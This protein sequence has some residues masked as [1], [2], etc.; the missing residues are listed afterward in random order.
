MNDKGNRYALSALK[1]RR[2][3]V[4]SEIVSLERQMKHC[5]DSL[6]HVDATLRLLDE[7]IDIDA[8]PNNGLRDGSSC[9]ATVAQRRE[10]WGAATT[11]SSP[12]CCTSS[13]RPRLQL[14]K[15]GVQIA[16]T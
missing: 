4:A 13:H 9:S 3:T 14:E 1:N 12:A 16:S 10:G 6:V 5:K 7:S 11:V 2:A 15:L 8:I